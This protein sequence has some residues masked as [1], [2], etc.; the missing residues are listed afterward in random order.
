MTCPSCAT[1]NAPGA[2]FCSSCGMRVDAAAL[3]ADSAAV[4]VAAPAAVMRRTRYICPHCDRATRPAPY[5]DRG[6]NVAKAVLLFIPLTFVG[7]VLF[8]LFRKDRF[9]CASCKG[10]LP[11]EAPVRLLQAFS[12]DVTPAP[13][14]L[15][16]A[17]E[18]DEISL[19]ERRSRKHRRRAW[20][21][22]MLSG[23]FVT[24]GTLAVGADAPVGFCVLVASVAGMSGAWSAIRA[25][26]FGKLA[27][28]R[29]RRQR[30]IQIL[31]LARTRKGRLTVSLVAAQLRLE[32]DEAEKAL[33]AL[34]DGRRVDMQVD[35]DGLVIYM[36]PE[37]ADRAG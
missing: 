18:D 32:L 22:G 3:V 30:T 2:R 26:T 13:G 7:P 33:D 5:F 27:E 6:A 14:L 23:S 4:T 34:V 1:Q 10:L 8:F 19:L 36:F 15:P 29:R 17:D 37:L 28:A 9:I 25:G 21:W 20:G 24:I 12:P 11:G 35:A 16:A 31:D